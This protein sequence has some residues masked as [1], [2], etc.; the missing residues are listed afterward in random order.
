M[1]SHRFQVPIRSSQNYIKRCVGL[2]LETL[3]IQHGDI[4][5]RPVDSKE[6]SIARKPPNVVEAMLQILSDT[7]HLAP[8][9]LKAGVPL[10]WQPSYAPGEGI[11]SWVENNELPTAPLENGW[12]VKADE[13]RFTA[14]LQKPAQG[15]AAWLRYYHRVLTPSQWSSIRKDGKLLFPSRPMRLDWY[16]TSQPITQGSLPVH[17]KS[18]MAKECLTTM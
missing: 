9:A 6:F 7:N 13:D 17:P 11:A 12:T 10:A 14:S 2:P 18:W 4:Y 3:R 8:S 1:G 5:V 15:Q 16:P